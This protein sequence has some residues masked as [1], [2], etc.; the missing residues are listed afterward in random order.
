MSEL[1]RKKAEAEGAA[2]EAEQ[3]LAQAHEAALEELRRELDDQRAKNN[4][5]RT[6][7]WEAVE[8]MRVG[9]GCCWLRTCQFFNT[10]MPCLASS[11]A[12]L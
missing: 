5:L 12:S 10:E 1:S 6:K 2:E 11:P 3:R 8:A 7:N 4:D 9:A